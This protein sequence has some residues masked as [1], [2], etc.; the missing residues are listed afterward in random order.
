[1]KTDLDPPCTG[2]STTMRHI[3][4]ISELLLK[5]TKNNLIENY[6]VVVSLYLTSN[7]AVIGSTRSS[8]MPVYEAVR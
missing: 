2:D 1:M 7:S 8:T 3:T 5:A 6:R 4:T